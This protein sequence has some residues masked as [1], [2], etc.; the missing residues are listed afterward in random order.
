MLKRCSLTY[1]HTLTDRISGGIAREVA[2]IYQRTLKPLDC[3][4]PSTGNEKS[5][6][7]RVETP[8]CSR[9]L[10]LLI[11]GARAEQS[12]DWLRWPL[13]AVGQRPIDTIVDLS[14]FVMLDL[15]Q[16]NHT[17]DATR[18]DTMSSE[19]II[20]VVLPSLLATLG[21]NRRNSD[22]VRLFEIGKGYR[23]ESASENGEPLEVHEVALVW[24]AVPPSGKDAAAF[25][26]DR[27]SQLY[28]VV[29]DLLEFLGMPKIEWTKA[30]SPQLWLKP[31]RP[32]AKVVRRT[33]N[34]STSTEART[35][36]RAA[37]PSPITSSCSRIPR[38]S[39]TRTRRVS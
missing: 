14:N 35:S 2:A 21:H 32:A 30:T 23:P 22:D 17:F 24:A 25:G 26:R 29:T 18:L 4:L 13:L 11:Q 6:P 27:F 36:T 16:P 3:T 8:G 5:Y 33:S 39:P 31:S 19:G 28:G 1:A 34:S 37:N 38:H 7:V 20:E 15:G 12:P 9:Y 10:G